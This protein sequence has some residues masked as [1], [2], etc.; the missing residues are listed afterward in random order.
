MQ[1]TGDTQSSTL[2]EQTVLRTRMKKIKHKIAVISGK[3]GVG[4]T[5]IAVNLAIAFAL[6]VTKTAS[7]FWTLTFMVPVFRRCL[8]WK[9][10]NLGWD[11]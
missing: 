1:A 8:A 7:V 5:V 10:K 6:Q 4:K 9:T 11:L 3:G 2:D